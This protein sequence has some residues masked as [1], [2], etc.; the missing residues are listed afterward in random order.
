MFKKIKK[1]RWL[2]KQNMLDLIP[3][4]TVPFTIRDD[5]RVVLQ[6]KRF[7]VKGMAKLLGKSDFVQVTLDEKGSIVWLRIDG[8]KTISNIC[9]EIDSTHAFAQQEMIEERVAA[10]ILTLYRQDYIDF[11]YRE[12]N[13]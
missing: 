11:V 8:Q 9:E 5:Q 10:F 7:P 4:R 13:Y 6:I 3:I 1:L 12:M 2:K